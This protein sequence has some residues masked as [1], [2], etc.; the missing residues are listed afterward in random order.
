MKVPHMNIIEMI[1]EWDR[2]LHT[3]RDQRHAQRLLWKIRIAV[4]KQTNEAT[5]AQTAEQER[6]RSFK[7]LNKRA[8]Q[9]RA[10]IDQL[11]AQASDSVRKPNPKRYAQI[12]PT[13]RQIAV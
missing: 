6:N 10:A 1:G 8:Q 4:Q 5:R 3:D 11:Q 13:R 2:I 12:D 7:D 9:V